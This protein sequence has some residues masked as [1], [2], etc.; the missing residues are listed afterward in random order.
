MI[1]HLFWRA[2]RWLKYLKPE[3]KAANTGTILLP[4]PLSNT[5]FPC[6]TVE[7]LAV[8]CRF[9]TH[10]KENDA[11]LVFEEPQ[12]ERFHKLCWSEITAEEYL[13]RRNFIWSNGGGFVDVDRSGDRA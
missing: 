10:L 8:I 4:G 2:T 6:E 7:E 11:F 9:A 3:S 5:S 1:K 12:K 13:S